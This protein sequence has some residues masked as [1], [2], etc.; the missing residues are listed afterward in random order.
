MKRTVLPKFKNLATDKVKAIWN[1][2]P[3]WNRRLIF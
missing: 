3:I 2:L 1:R